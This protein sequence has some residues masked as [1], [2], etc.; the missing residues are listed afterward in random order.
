MVEKAVDVLQRV[1]KKITRELKQWPGN[2][3]KATFEVNKREIPHLMHSPSQ[4]LFGFNTVGSLEVN[5]Q[6]KKKKSLLSALR[7][8]VSSVMLEDE[9]HS[10]NEPNK[11]AGRSSR[12]V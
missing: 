6:T 9:E 8:D 10:D 12:A 2:M 3:D 11:D 1:L 4:I 7:I 5:F